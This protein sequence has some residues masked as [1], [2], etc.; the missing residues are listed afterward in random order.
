MPQK[1]KGKIIHSKMKKG[2]TVWITGDT[3]G[4]IDISKLPNGLYLIRDIKGGAV[5]KIIVNH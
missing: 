5:N 1:K 2:T 3:H 4:E